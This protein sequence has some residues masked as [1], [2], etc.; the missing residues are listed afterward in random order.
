[1]A[2]AAA[3]AVILLGPGAAA[4]AKDCTGATPLPAD[5]TI[6]A[7]A[8]D[9]PPDLA[10]FSGGWGGVWIDRAGT[11]TSCTTLVVEEVLPNGYVRVVYSIGAFHPHTPVPQYWRASGRIVA[12]VLRFEVPVQGRHEFTYRF[13]G[14]DLAGEYKE[15]A[16][17]VTVTA[18]RLADVRRADC[19]RLPPVAARSGAARDRI[20]ATELLAS[21]FAV[22]AP[23][24]N[25]YFMP[26]GT[27]TPAHHT[28]RGTLTIPGLQLM[29]AHDGCVGLPTPSPGFT[30]PVFTHGDSLVPA[31]RTIV[32]SSDSRYGIIL[33][34]GRV[35][36]EPG[37]RGMSRASFPFVVVNAYD[38]GTLNGLA[39]FV[40]D[41]TRVSNLRAQ[42]TQETMPWAR[43]DYW[44]QAPMTYAPGAI[45]DEARLRARFDAERRL[46]TPITPWSALPVPT[47]SASLDAF[48]GS[49]R[50]EDISVSGAVVDG[51][52]YAK[53]C[54]TRT[55]AHPYCRHM[56]HAAFSVT[57]TLGA[58]IA[59]L[60][61]AA[62]YGDGVFE[63]KISDY[64][65]VTATHDGWK[66]VTFADALSMVV[67][68]GDVV[69]R[70]DS[71]QP[72][73]DDF[74]PRAFAWFAKRTAQEK[75][76]HGFTF[77]RYTWARGE[78]VRYNSTVTFTL[79]AAMDAFL[80][81]KEGP[82][83]HLWDMV[84]D[85]VYRPIG[86]LHAPM[87]H[88]VEP[89]G[90]RGIPLL[91]FG[92]TPTIDEVAKL[93][94]LLQAR[95]RHDGVQILSAAKIDEA[96]RRTTAGLSTRVLSRFGEQRYHLSV[97]SLPY[98]TALGCRFDVPYMWGFGGSFVVLLPNGV[99]AFRFA[100]GQ[101]HDL[102]TMILAGEAIRPFCTSAPADAPA[103]AVQT[104]PLT[105]AEL[106][107]E[108]PGNTFSA[109]ALRAFLAP[110]GR[111]YSAGGTG[112]DVG[113]WRITAEGL[114]CRTWNV[115]D[116]GRERCHHVYRD[117]ETFT[118]HVHDRWT[119]FRWTRTLGRSAGF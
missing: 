92:L 29:S 15:V 116:G 44:G 35:W 23:V 36:A 94:M 9:V 60:R 97:W 61:L 70:R 77:G 20:L 90:G 33:S 24:H 3:L 51:V 19:P 107:A 91:A 14:N 67:P 82:N 41:D 26:I 85:E 112:V 86:I 5:T 39:T 88:T 96:L 50:R 42:I 95:G 30:V 16:V 100:D 21:T 37:D 83:A 69:P 117:G 12:G 101:V 98:R 99:S 74:T 119:V 54:Q 64:V 84:A 58:G 1:L 31:V 71:Q 7:P 40:F 113:R 32:P 105:A 43:H 25:D 59:L 89:G 2:I 104:P 115:S 4:D 65:R 110:D 68:I 46:E 49:A 18:T 75:L 66:D 106:R 48:D 78:V 10:R 73:A 87:M 27:A 8:A 111:Q 22:D 103:K 6:T 55:G 38:N 109:G 47:R 13:A 114:Y 17:V 28:L 45:V 72:M 63:L 93:A 52:V 34:P 102:E 80:K 76:D 56:R 62:K 11:S 108:L 57:K 81:Q 53:D 118:F 79:A